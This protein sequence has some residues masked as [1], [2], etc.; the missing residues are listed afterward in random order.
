M[1]QK[2]IDRNRSRW[3]AKRGVLSMLEDI[4]DSDEF[5]CSVYI[6]PKSLAARD[7]PTPVDWPHVSALEAAVD[8]T[9]SPDTGLAVF[10]AETRS[11]AVVPPFPLTADLVCDG[12]D[13]TPM[14]RLLQSEPTVGVVLLRLGRY[15]VGVLRGD[16][17]VA[18]KT[19]S[20]YMKNRHRAGGQSQRRFERSRE[21]LIRELYDKACEVVGDVFSPYQRAMDHVMF[22]GERHTLDGLL[23]R[24]RRLRDVEGKTLG[25]LLPV[26]S[27][28]Q[29]A[30]QG[31]ARE[32]WMSRIIRFGDPHGESPER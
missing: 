31:I 32:V 6:T 11:I 4:E 27:P 24:C 19:A 29:K 14:R 21:R 26:D 17:L 3:T 18:S 7:Y 8:A 22:G 1:A 10:V 9:G 5:V 20:R 2:K 23:L 30:L 25:R 16:K 28:N 12:A 15:A 13:V